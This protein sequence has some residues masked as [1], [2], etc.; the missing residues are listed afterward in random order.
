MMD[1]YHALSATAG[2]TDAA[3]MVQN[4]LNSL[5]GTPGLGAAPQAEGKLYPLLSDLLDS[6]STVDM[7]DSLSESKID[8]LL[9]LLPPA[10]VILSQRADS[11]SD[12]GRDQTPDDAVA[13]LAAMNIDRKRSL[14]KRVLRSPQFHQSLT[15]LTLALRDGGLPTVS[16]A[17]G[18]QVAN[19]G[20]IKGSAVPLGGGEAVEAF[21]EG[22]KKAVQETKHTE[23]NS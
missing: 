3:A 13:A 22:V 5:K 18:I 14:L 16:E 17:L 10:V 4:L 2:A 23:A 1:A 20:R 12:I 9:K 19:G 6:S 8:T 11:P 21:V 7:A 15:S